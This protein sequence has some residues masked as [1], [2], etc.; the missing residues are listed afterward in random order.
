M[1]GTDA[2]VTVLD[3]R[4]LALDRAQ[5]FENGID[6]GTE[7]VVVGEV[8]A[9]CAEQI[10]LLRLPWHLEGDCRERWWWEEERMNDASGHARSNNGN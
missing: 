6:M 4:K 5:P 9:I 2:R 8:S 10:L 7:V 3:V 1:R